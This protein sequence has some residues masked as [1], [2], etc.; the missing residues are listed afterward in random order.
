MEEAVVEA[1]ERPKVR[2]QY[3]AKQIGRRLLRALT[4]GRED[5]VLKWMG[6]TCEE[7]IDQVL[8]AIG[9]ARIVD[10]LGAVMERQREGQRSVFYLFMSC[11]KH[12]NKYVNFL[13][14]LR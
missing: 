9:P 12:Q 1:G 5:H 13:T 6:W 11:Q 3:S 14:L 8:E 10:L 4:E 2:K 7:Q